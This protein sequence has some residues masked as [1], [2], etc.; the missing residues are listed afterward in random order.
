LLSG[1]GGGTGAG[2][3]TPT[4]TPTPTLQPP[5]APTIG[6]ATPGDRTA[7]IAFTPPASNG[8]ASVTGYAA[9]CT[10]GGGSVAATGST[11]PLTV[12]GLVNGSVY[13]CAVTA[14]NSVGTGA[15]S[16]AVT[17]T[18]VGSSAATTPNI[19]FII[20]DDFGLD[21]SP[22]HPAVGAS[23]PTMPNLSALCQRGVVFDRAWAHPTCTPTRASLLTGKYGVHTN[24]L[25]VD[26]VLTDTD[27]ILSRVQQGANPYVTA[28]I[29][30]WH[31]SGANA[32]ANSPASFG[33]Q[34]F[35]GFLSGAL[36][37]YFNWRI[38]ENGTASNTTTYATT[39]LTD[40]AITW[41][42]AQRQPWFLWLAYNAPHAPFHT[43]PE[44]LHTQAGLKNGTATDNR[45]RYFAAAEALDAELGR[46]LASIPAATLS[47]TT[48][49]FMG[50]NGTPGQVIQSPYSSAKAK[51]SLYQGGINVPLVAAG[52]GVTRA[53]QREQAL[54][55]G[56]DLFATFAD[57]A[58]R[59]QNIPADSISFATTLR[60]AGNAGRSHAYIDFRDS[61]T[62]A[63]AIR[64]TRYKLIESGSGRRELYDLQADPYEAQDL[65][66]SGSTAALDTIVQGLVAQRA[67]FQR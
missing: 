38:T 40:K 21:A 25:A 59:S 7:T 56:S 1:C 30:K 48:I 34:F 14:T 31:V 17:V 28:A 64:D 5:G 2:G 49:V 12:A 32:A 51:D 62:I 41:V 58:Q 11:S 60:S 33:A 26:E 15:S 13:S 46:L 20:A 53:G 66:A 29:G 24:V 36:T 39:L 18:P 57:L 19:L 52:A 50:D 43:P 54:V 37:D 10:G 44:T 42:A 9:T 67:Q 61:G 6:V 3:A 23:K 63:T 4:P 22:C 45:T 65:L 47:N 55:N 27:T 35:S 8:G 16:A